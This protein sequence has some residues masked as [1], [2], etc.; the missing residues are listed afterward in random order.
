M[1]HEGLDAALFVWGE[2]V[3]AGV[4][5]QL[6]HGYK[7]V[8]AC[9]GELPDAFEGRTL[10]YGWLIAGLLR[11]AGRRALVPVDFQGRS[12]SIWHAVT[13]C[14]SFRAAAAGVIQRHWRAWNRLAR[15]ARVRRQAA[16]RRIQKGCHAWILKPRTADGLAGVNLRIL[17]RMKCPGRA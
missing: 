14:P 8:L 2:A 4:R 17:L 15:L 13:A 5:A 9:F 3:D 16:A 11:A 10:P 1:W 7:L 12:P 6:A